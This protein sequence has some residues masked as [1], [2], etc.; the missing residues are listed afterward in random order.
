M[1]AVLAYTSEV[2]EKWT[3]SS[4]SLVM[5]MLSTLFLRLA[6]LTL[7]RQ[8][9]HRHAPREMRQVHPRDMI[10][11]CYARSQAEPA[12]HRREHVHRPARVLLTCALGTTMSTITFS[13]AR[14]NFCCMDIYTPVHGPTRRTPPANSLQHAPRPRHLVEESVGLQ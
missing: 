2:S 8:P 11:N 4:S 6:C 12:L 7:K 9:V 5:N 13:S 10:S 1:F 3:L 14:L